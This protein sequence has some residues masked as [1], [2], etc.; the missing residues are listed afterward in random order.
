MLFHSAAFAVF[1]PIVWTLYWLL[2]ETKQQNALLL[3][4]SW[5][6]YGWWDARFLLLLGFSIL[7]DYTVA[8]RIAAAREKGTQVSRGPQGRE[9]VAQRGE[10]ERSVGPREGGKASEGHRAGRPWITLS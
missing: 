9:V 3:A 8:L 7:V 6:F 4:A 10:A 2:R 1:L 5:V